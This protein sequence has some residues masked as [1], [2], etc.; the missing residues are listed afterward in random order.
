[1]TPQNKILLVLGRRSM[2]WSFPKGHKERGESYLEC[3]IR[4]TLEETGIDLRCE[5]PVSY[6]RL[7]VGKYYFFEVEEQ[8]TCIQD[9]REVLEARW[10]TVDEIQESYCNVDVSNFLM[11]LK[12]DSRSFYPRN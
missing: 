2:K 4:E 12:K 7:S 10:M 3:A 1:M 8:P 11:R 5:T 6:Q 9:P